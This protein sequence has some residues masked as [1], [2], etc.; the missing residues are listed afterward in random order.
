M[1]KETR[2][3]CLYWQNAP[4]RSINSKFSYAFLSLLLF[5]FFQAT[6]FSAGAPEIYTPSEKKRLTSAKSLDNRIRV[7]DAAFERIRKEL[8]KDMRED[9]FDDAARKL[10]NWSVLLSESLADIEANSNPK[11]RSN[12]LRQYETHLR[13]AVNGMRSISM[14]APTTELYGAFVSFME[15]AEETRRKFMNIIFNME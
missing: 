8:E 9:R 5:F 13:Q 11:R 14:R 10:S 3:K 12:R 6:A 2:V 15:Q 7:Y 1:I 4:L